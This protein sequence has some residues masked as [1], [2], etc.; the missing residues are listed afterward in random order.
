MCSEM[1]IIS[2]QMGGRTVYILGVS[3]TVGEICHVPA[4][5]V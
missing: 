2:R 5:T 3:C 1:S 4:G